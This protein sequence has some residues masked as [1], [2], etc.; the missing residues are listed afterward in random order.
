M[1]ADEAAE[2]VIAGLLVNLRRTAKVTS[3]KS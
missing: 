1:L 2:Q 3:L